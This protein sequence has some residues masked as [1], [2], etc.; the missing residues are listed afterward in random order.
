MELAKSRSL[1]DAGS[2]TWKTTVMTWDVYGAAERLSDAVRTIRGS[3]PTD[4][5]R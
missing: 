1:M 2:G 4:I 5:G 3:S